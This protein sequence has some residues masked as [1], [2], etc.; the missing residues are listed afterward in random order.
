MNKWR[1]VGCP[2]ARL[3]HIKAKHEAPA[4]AMLRRT[5]RLAGQIAY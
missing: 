2:S 4:Y 1:V 5:S 3:R